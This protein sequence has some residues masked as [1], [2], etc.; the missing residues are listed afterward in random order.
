MILLK[1]HYIISVYIKI[2]HMSCY[3]ATQLE[4]SSCSALKSSPSFRCY[5]EKRNMTFT[6]LVD[7]FFPCSVLNLHTWIH[8]LLVF[9]LFYGYSYSKMLMIWKFVPTQMVNKAWSD[10][11]CTETVNPSSLD[12]IVLFVVRPWQNKS[13]QDFIFKWQIERSQQHKEYLPLKI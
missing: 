7:Q 2:V 4:D 9:S 11:T 13:N 1:S 10:D 5:L 12:R 6:G 3:I 8:F